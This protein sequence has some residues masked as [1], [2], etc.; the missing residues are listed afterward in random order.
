MQRL[1][2]PREDTKHGGVQLK[3]ITRGPMTV[4]L[5]RWIHDSTVLCL[6]DGV[7]TLCERTVGGW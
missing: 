5:A 6:A 4:A 1:R 7:V 2:S 3:V